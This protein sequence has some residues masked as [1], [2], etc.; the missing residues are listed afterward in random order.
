MYNSV[1]EQDEAGTIAAKNCAASIS[2]D[3]SEAHLKM[4]LENMDVAGMGLIRG[5]AKLFF[6]A[7][8]YELLVYC[9]INNLSWLKTLSQWWW[10]LNLILLACD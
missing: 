4:F 8:Y 5:I 2:P 3:C 10:D 6:P 7:N 9:S 1:I